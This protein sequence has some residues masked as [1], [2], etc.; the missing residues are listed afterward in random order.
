MMNNS[1]PDEQFIWPLYSAPVVINIRKHKRERPKYDIYIGRA[2]R[3][4]EF[5][6]DSK[7]HNP[8]R[9]DEWGDAALLMYHEYI[10]NLLSGTPGMIVM[11]LFNTSPAQQKA[12]D[13][14]VRRSFK[15]WGTKAWDIDELTGK[16]IGCW[17]VNATT[18][19]NPKCHGQILIKLWHERFGGFEH[20]QATS[21]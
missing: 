20:G 17:C 2:T 6:E 19:D 16:R 8:F 3:Y 18:C 5:T 1:L 7:W 4:T 13:A 11:D 10:T 12:I 9:K 14:A 15:R 21:T